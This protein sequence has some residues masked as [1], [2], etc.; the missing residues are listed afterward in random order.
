MFWSECCFTVSFW[1]LYGEIF[2]TQNG[3]MQKQYI[4]L[5]GELIGVLAGDELFFTHANY[6]NEPWLVTD[7]SGAVIWQNLTAP[8]GNSAETYPKVAETHPAFTLKHIRS[9]CPL[10]LSRTRGIFT[11]TGPTPVC[12]S[13]SGR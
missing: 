10:P 1:C 5:D 7:P 3:A 9:P 8:F 4:W 2:F 13:R 12:I 6:R 11:F